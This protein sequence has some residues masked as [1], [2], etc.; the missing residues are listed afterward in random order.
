[1][2]KVT[3]AITPAGEEI[4][5]LSRAEYERLAE[6]ANEAEEDAGTARIVDRARARLE[7]GED[8]LVPAEFA[9]RIAGGESALRVVRQWRELDQA[10]LGAAAGLSQAYVSDL[11][12]GAR[13]GGADVWRSLAAALRVPIDLIMP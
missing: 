2:S 13:K 5:I 9:Y 1:M 8:V 6:L 4:A 3:F 7:R 10:E 11:E 12:R